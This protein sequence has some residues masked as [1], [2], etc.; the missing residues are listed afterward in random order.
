MDEYFVDEPR[1]PI[2]GRDTWKDLSVNQLIEIK[3]Q[4]YDKYW[5]FKNTSPQIAKVLL[6]NVNYLTY[7]IQKPIE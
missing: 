6:D 4:L 1:T 7:L 3:N 2:P 5:F